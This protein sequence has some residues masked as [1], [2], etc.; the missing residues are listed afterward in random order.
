MNPELYS[1]WG[2]GSE[3]NFAIYPCVFILVR[4]HIAL[5]L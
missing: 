5:K 4:E 1:G 3:E 2:G